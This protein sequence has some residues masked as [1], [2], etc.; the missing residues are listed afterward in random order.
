VLHGLSDMANRQ[1]LGA[2][3]GRAPG[4]RRSPTS[5]LFAKAARLLS[6]SSLSLT[7]AALFLLFLVGQALTG[8]RVYSD[9][10]LEHGAG[11]IDFLSYLGS[12]HFLEA[13]FENWESEFLQMAMFVLLTVR[14][15]QKGSSESKARG[16]PHPSEEDPR[17]HR[18][19]PDAPWPVRR[20]GFALALYEH[21]LSI[22]LFTIFAASFALHAATGV[23][24]FNQ[25]R[26]QHGEPVV[27]VWGYVS[28]SEFWFE[29]FQ[30]WQSEFLAVLGIVLLTIFLRQRGSPQSKPV[31]APHAST[32]D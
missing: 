11:P 1:A 21:S 8:Y 5:P 9:E 10:L 25:E 28:S 31:A 32:N 2:A 19:N 3:S 15:Y 20:G 29:S 30:N 14:L 23:R 17:Q 12:G 27:G 24:L 13:T 7:L 6:E 16:E 26:L 22:A 18:D 4:H